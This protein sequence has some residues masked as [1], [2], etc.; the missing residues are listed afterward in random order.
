MEKIYPHDKITAALIIL[1][2]ENYKSSL[3]TEKFI[4]I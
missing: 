4:K 1:L 3:M 2:L